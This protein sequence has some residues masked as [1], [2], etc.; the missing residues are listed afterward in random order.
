MN[1]LVIASFILLKIHGCENKLN[2][3][4]VH[5]GHGHDHANGHDHDD[6]LHASERGL[7]FRYAHDASEY[8]HGC[9]RDGARGCIFFYSIFYEHARA[10]LILDYDCDYCYDHD[11]DH[12]CIFIL[13]YAN[14]DV[15][16]HENGSILDVLHAQC[17]NAILSLYKDCIQ[18][19]RKKLKAY[20]RDLRLQTY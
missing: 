14:D 9:V 12:D 3:V 10:S 4:C 18:G 2:Y 6:S 20:I 5:H 15:L 8:D 16:D 7:Q 1:L 13:I 19:Q 17:P 11:H